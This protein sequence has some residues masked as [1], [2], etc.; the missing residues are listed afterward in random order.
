M[1]L[2]LVIIL[3]RNR[4]YWK[5]RQ[6]QISCTPNSSRPSTAPSKD[7]FDSTI[8][9]SSTVQDTNSI[10]IVQ[11]TRPHSSRPSSA[12]IA[13]SV[14][15]TRSHLADYDSV[16]DTSQSENR[17]LHD[18]QN[19]RFGERSATASS[20]R[21]SGNIL[22]INI[23]Y[24]DLNVFS[25]RD[26]TATWPLNF[27]VLQNIKSRLASAGIWRTG[28]AKIRPLTRWKSRVVGRPAWCHILSEKKVS[29]LSANSENH[30]LLKSH[31]KNL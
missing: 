6:N 18:T 5:V 29:T 14:L 13:R 11:S 30:H 28:S 1:V 23:Y 19:T 20:R 10:R 26:Q 12:F 4:G 24:V 9:W 21:S 2:T 25:N 7:P 17:H 31:F 27:S 8:D 16:R 15:R 3:L 22:L